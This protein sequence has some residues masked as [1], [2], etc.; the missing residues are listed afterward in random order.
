MRSSGQQESSQSSFDLSSAPLPHS[1]SQA[2]PFPLRKLSD[3]GLTP[4]FPCLA[5]RTPPAY[6]MVARTLLPS[7]LPSYIFLPPRA[8]SVALWLTELCSAPHMTP[9]KLMRKGVPTSLCWVHTGTPS[10]A[11]V[12]MVPATQLTWVQNRKGQPN[13]LSLYN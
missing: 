3:H 8:R 11:V 10:R 5:E 1:S 6:F 13:P 7:A 4:T 9:G 2:F 12:G